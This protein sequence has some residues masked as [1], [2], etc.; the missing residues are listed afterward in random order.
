MAG[1][2]DTQAREMLLDE[3]KKDSERN[4]NNNNKNHDGPIFVL[5][6]FISVMV[7][8]AGD[9]EAHVNSI[10]SRLPYLFPNLEATFLR[11]CPINSNHGTA[12]KN[13]L[14]I[15]LFIFAGFIAERIFLRFIGNDHLQNEDLPESNDTG[16]KIS[17]SVIRQIPTVLGLFVFFSAAY[18]TNI[19]T[20]G[21]DLHFVQLAFFCTLTCII[22]CRIVYMLSRFIIAPHN[23]SFR[24]IPLTDKLAK[25]L[26]RFFVGSMGF[27]FVGAMLAILV[28][29]LGDSYEMYVFITFAIS[30]I[31]IL[32]AGCYIVIYKSSITNYILSQSYSPQH[33]E[34]GW[35]RKHFSS[36][37]HY[38][39]ILYL[40]IV[41]VMTVNNLGDRGN[42][43]GLAFVISFFAIPLW[44]LLDRIVIWVVNYGVNILKPEELDEKSAFTIE[45]IET[46]KSEDYKFV[47]KLHKFARTIL[48]ISLGIWL[49]SFWGFRMPI[50]DKISQGVFDSILICGVAII[51]WRFFCKWVHRKIL[52]SLPED[53]EEEENEDGMGST[54]KSKSRAYTL[55]PMLRKFIGAILF[56]MVVMTIL[57]QLGVDIGPLLAGAG[58]FG[59]AIGFGA[60]KIVADIFS[61]FFYLLDDAF[62][63]G[64][65]LTAGSVTGTVESIS[66]RNVFL[67]H[68][69]GM[70][71]IVPHSEMGAITNSN[72]GGI[73]VKFNL[74]FPYDADI[75]KIRKI[76]KKVGIAMLEDEELK[77][78][79]ILPVKSQGV[80]EITNSVMTIRVKFTAHPG[81]QFVIRREAYRRL[82]EALNHKGIF[83]AHRKVIVDIPSNASD[84]MK[85]A[86]GAAALASQPVQPTPALDPN[87]L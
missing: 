6:D 44:F 83:Y 10:G 53:A 23:S 70:L 85:K 64:E 26:H 46:R 76:I 32:V 35:G 65:Y 9:F 57:S 42:S 78:D 31:L 36:I 82:T 43:T 55:L 8:S 14:Y 20:L 15:A 37:W 58:V 69:L 16:S 2:S 41:W 47:A 21:T 74:D 22:L 52:A 4:I 56:V 12:G 13:L 11:L 80:R 63:V 50:I 73:V 39:A 68:H 30:T 84:D 45:Q 54:S 28:N 71:Q 25:T 79:F 62:R 81:K 77:D 51:F 87:A 38:C 27:I 75:D 17:A 66:L 29:R 67:R 7:K 18:I 1:L 61:G 72:R 49:A 5:N 59:L 19:M 24:F 86:A 48:A 60:Q 33:E 3:L 40:I 34:A